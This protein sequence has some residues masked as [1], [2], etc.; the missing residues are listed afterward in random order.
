MMFIS[1]LNNTQALEP[2][3][4]LIA[5]VGENRE[6]FLSD[7]RFLFRSLAAFGGMLKQ[8]TKI[9]YVVDEADEKIVEDL[10]KLGVIVKIVGRF[11][12]RYPHA[13]KLRMLQDREDYDVLV[14]LDCDI[15]VSK[16]FFSE[17]E[18]GAVIAKPVDTDPLTLDQW[19]T[20]FRYFGM[21]LPRK[22][23]LTTFD[24]RETI[25]YFNSGVIGIPRKFVGK[26]AMVWESML[27]KMED[28]YHEFPDINS[29]R[30]FS[31]QFAFALALNKAQIPVKA[32]PVEMNCPLHAPI[33]PR[34]KPDSM[35][36]YLLHHHH[37]ITSD[38][39]LPCEHEGINRA[40]AAINS[41]LMS[42]MGNSSELFHGSINQ[43][44]DSSEFWDS[45]Y[46]S[47]MKL[48]S[49]LGSRGDS[50][51]YK[52]AVLRKVTCENSV[53]SVLDVGCG[54]LEVTSELSLRNY[55]G[56]DFSRAITERNRQK[57]PDRLFLQG[58]F[59]EIASEE[60]LSADLVLCL[61]VLIH[62][63]DRERY[64]QMVQEL[65]KHTK[66]VG[67]VGAYQLPPRNE[68]CSH[69]TAFHE[70]ITQTLRRAGATNISLIG[71]YRD[72]SLVC[73]RRMIRLNEGT[74]DQR[75]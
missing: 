47:D 74:A 9:A 28:A 5:C 42:P 52:Q 11:D 59:L 73:Y 48:G 1:R 75:S 41:V 10:G 8:A 27:L 44:F 61:D 2:Q 67:L 50:L 13:N 21:R 26:L 22:R 30:F 23:Y 58:D 37:R 3:R 18:T 29:H 17:L 57:K 63:H 19:K 7:M 60:Q 36:P 6:P 72:T 39:V 15:V 34:F 62:E 32:L 40:L 53:S 14:A 4:V 33:H 12:Q 16:D 31:D 54:D 35:A 55:V 45:R 20:L 25:P 38:G 56:V 46:R 70:P 43:E 71:Y 24:G 69:I 51:A 65:V 64:L 66:R 49:G 68:F